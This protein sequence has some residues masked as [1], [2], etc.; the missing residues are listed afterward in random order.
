M[1]SASRLTCL[2]CLAASALLLAG[3][4]TPPGGDTAA[5]ANP[6]IAPAPAAATIQPVDDPPVE[7]PEAY[8]QCWMKYDKS[9]ASLEAKAKLVDK[10]AADKMM[11]N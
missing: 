9:G 3:C 1:I 10:C 7:R 2:I 6:A 5:T 11:G 4:T 8:A